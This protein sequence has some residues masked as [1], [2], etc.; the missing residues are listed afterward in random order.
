LQLSEVNPLRPKRVSRRKF[1]KRGLAAGIALGL[2]DSVLAEPH[3]LALEKVELPISGLG[4]E[5]DGYRVALLS[6]FHY[7][8]HITK[9]HI[10][11]AFELAQSF[12]PHIICLLGDFVHSRSYMGRQR[13]SVPEIA[14]VFNVFRA[15]DG[16]IGV[17]GNHDHWMDASAVREQLKRTSIKL[18]D[19]RSHIVRKGSSSLAFVGTADFWEEQIDFLQAFDGIPGDVPRILLQHNPDL[20]EVMPAQYRVDLQVSGHTHGGQ[21]RIPFGPAPMLPT[22]Y[23]NKYRAGLV[24]GPRYRVYVTRGVGMSSPIPLRFWCRPEVTAITLRKS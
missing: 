12:K 18:I 5:F 15:D 3:W 13:Q 2:G 23:G 20:A 16:V 6:D 17:L 21:V 10:A 24:N 8:N 11:K 14:S 9:R 19:N 7:D 22:K 4:Q 1:I